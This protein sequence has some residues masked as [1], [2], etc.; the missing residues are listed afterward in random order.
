M[1]LYQYIDQK[2]TEAV[3]SVAP[4][5]TEARSV[6]SARPGVDRQYN[7]IMALAKQRGVDP[8]ELA[9]AV[10]LKLD[11]SL[12]DEIT[13]DKPGF[14]NLH[15]SDAAILQAIESCEQLEVQSNQR[16]RVIIDFGGP[17]IAKALHVGHLRSLVIGESL[18]RILIARGHAVVSDIHFGDWGMPMGMLVAEIVR[19]YPDFPATVPEQFGVVLEHLYPQVVEACAADRTRMA[20]A[21]LVTAN[22]QSGELDWIWKAL[23]RES[24][25][26]IM[27]QVARIGAHFD[28]LYGESDAQVHIVAVA[29]LLQD[30]LRIDDGAMIIDVMTPNDQKDIPPLIF[31]KSD[32]GYTYAASDLGTILMRRWFPV[33]R[34]VQ[35]TGRILYVVDKRQALHFEQVFRAARLLPFAKHLDLVHV[36]FG[37]VNGPDGRPYRTREGDTPSLAGLLDTAIEMA[38]QRIADPQ[39][40]EIV[41]IGAIKYADLVTNRESGYVFDLGR[42]LAA[43]GKTG[44]YVQYACVR[45]KKILDAGLDKGPILISHPTERDVLLT[46]ANFPEMVDLA[47][48]HLLPSYLAEYAFTLAQAV[49]RF[50]DHCDVLKAGPVIQA[51]RLAICQLAY[52]ILRKSLELLGIEVP[53]RM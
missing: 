15:V 11:D 1:P 29:K 33:H 39:T 27:P 44:P 40:A 16:Q 6:I 3:G 53:E 19:R 25:A 2:L 47:E 12:F 26:S 49:S 10:A 52:S 4:P 22:L 23:R 9:A 32:G 38:A 35:P 31:Q 8:M 45:L 37:T 41:G 18:R 14:I 17:N 42:L 34:R 7:G 43:E 28:H 30:A 13:A 50:Y 51:S 21:H 20:E 36:G 46:C 24:L 48:K 5:P